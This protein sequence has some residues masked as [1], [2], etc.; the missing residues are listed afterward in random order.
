MTNRTN[1]NQVAKEHNW[2]VIM[3]EDQYGKGYLHQ[4]MT[5]AQR[6]VDREGWAFVEYGLTASEAQ[7]LR[8]N[9]E[10]GTVQLHEVA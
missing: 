7:D 6:A 5:Y 4:P 8:Q 9:L 3:I 10:N 2:A 1:A